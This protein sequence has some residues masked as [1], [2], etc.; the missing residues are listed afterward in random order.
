[1][2]ALFFVRM[3]II[4]SSAG[5]LFLFRLMRLLIG[6]RDIVTG[7]GWAVGC[8]DDETSGVVECISFGQ[9]CLIHT[10]R[11]TFLACVRSL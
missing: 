5:V 10:T 3:Y 4:V 6:C 9:P 2:I 8:L 1:M 11:R 7:V